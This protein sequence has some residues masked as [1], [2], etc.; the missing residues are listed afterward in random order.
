MENDNQLKEINNKNCKKLLFLLHTFPVKNNLA[1]KKFS[2]HYRSVKI[3]VACTQFSH[4]SPT[5]FSLTVTFTDYFWE[6]Y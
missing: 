4:F 2:K 5:T 3:L 1:E 6:N